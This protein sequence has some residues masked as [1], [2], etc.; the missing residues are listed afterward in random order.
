MEFLRSF[1]RILLFFLL[2]AFLSHTLAKQCVELKD[3]IN[4]T[5]VVVMPN[6]VVNLTF[7]I[8]ESCYPDSSKLETVT[9]AS[10]TS[11][12]TQHYCQFIH[13]QSVCDNSYHSYCSCDAD[14]G[15]YS[16]SIHVT[17]VRK[18]KWEITGTFTGN[19]W[20]FNNYVN[21]HAKSSMDIEF[22]SFNGSTFTVMENTSTTLAFTIST[23]FTLDDDISLFPSLNSVSVERLPYSSSQPT[24][25][26]C[27]FPHTNGL[28]LSGNVSDG[29]C[30]C[31]PATNSYQFTTWVDRQLHHSQWRVK[32]DFQEGAV[33]PAERRFQM[34]V[35]YPPQVQRIT[36][37]S[38]GTESHSAMKQGMAVKVTC[39]WDQ[40]NPP[41]T[42]VF[43]DDDSKP[44]KSEIYNDTLQIEY[45]NEN[46]SC[47]DIGVIHCKAVGASVN[48]SAALLVQCPP[49]FP[50]ER[51]RTFTV[52]RGVKFTAAFP[53]R[54][55]TNTVTHWALHKVSENNSK[56]ITNHHVDLSHRGVLEITGSPPTLTASLTLKLNSPQDEALW[57]LEVT[58]HVGTGHVEFK[59]RI[60]LP[61]DSGGLLPSTD[62]GIALLAV[63]VT[64][65]LV[66]VI[67]LYVIVRKRR[68]RSVECP[69]TEL[70][71]GNTTVALQL[72]YDRA[73][74]SATSKHLYNEIM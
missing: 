57:R 73:S 41:Q 34:D 5:D 63:V 43:L 15:E 45:M 27:T 19:I 62:F 24:T 72:K 74:E 56:T 7:G 61:D 38:N 48:K 17:N 31:D 65:A 22:L 50:S 35:N 36:I 44:L 13:E 54:A 25:R 2:S 11:A 52:P 14:T 67:V 70:S 9:T 33:L 58:N 26:L 68:A 71:N 53:M 18:E 55:H 21:L 30:T 40:G 60:V 49:A 8:N 1:H 66:L 51:Q 59:M 6:S 20:S 16:A 3:S 29:N 12:I 47:E 39:A 64:C 10:E 28:C 4:N 42:A 46:V 69:S 37:T 23:S 32:L